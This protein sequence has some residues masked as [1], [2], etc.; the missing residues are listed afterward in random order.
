[1]LWYVIPNHA[2]DAQ[3]S[4]EKLI[5]STNHYRFKNFI[6]L[7]GDKINL[8]PNTL[9]I[10]NEKAVVSLAGIVGGKNSGIDLNTTEA[11][12]EMAIY[13]ETRVRQDSRKLKITT[14]ASTRL[15]KKLDTQL[16]PQAFKHLIHLILTSCS[17]TVSSN[18]VDIYP[19]KPPSRKIKF[20]PHK[21]SQYAGIAI[22]E[23]FTS[24]TLKKLGCKIKGRSVIP[25]SGRADLNLEEDLIEEAIRFYGYDK[26]PTDQPISNKKL[27]DITPKILYLIETVKNILVNIGYDEVRSWPLIRERDIYK[28]RELP[29]NARPVYTQNNINSDYPVLR[30]SIISSLITQKK[31]YQKFKVDNRQFFEIG[32]IFYR[33]GPKYYEHYSLAMYNQS[34]DQLRKDGQRLYRQLGLKKGHP[35]I[36]KINSDPFIEIDLGKLIREI[37]T[38]PKI[39]IIQAKNGQEATVGL[40]RQIITQDVNIF[41]SH[42][43]NP[44]KLIAQYSQKIP[45]QYLWQMKVID[46]YPNS[47]NNQY[48]YTL[49]VSYLNTNHKTAQQIHRKAFNLPQ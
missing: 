48:K 9:I 7:E 22:P 2:F 4:G 13:N 5:W 24:A 14:E 26:I 37:A 16:I 44:Q 15:E 17:G 10:H 32:K 35:P 28:N 45:S 20:S 31:Q 36:T 43:E 11:I 12:V 1:M 49:R 27:T 8:G 6:T 29:K 46:I 40:S 38:I 33:I 19:Q 47:Q 25:P 30:Q 18:L 42:R 39:N 23:K 3:K 21:V 34:V 41:L